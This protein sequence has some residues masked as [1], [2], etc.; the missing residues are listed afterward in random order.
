[1]AV[2]HVKISTIADSTDLTLVRP[3][4]WNSSHT[5]EAGSI[6]NI[7]ISTAAAVDEAKITFSTA[8]GH[9]HNAVNSKAVDHV[10]LLNKGSNS[11]A[12]IDTHISAATPH[13]GHENSANKNIANG[14]QGLNANARTSSTNI[15]IKAI[16]ATPTLD[17][18]LDDTFSAGWI[19]GG[20][21]FAS[22]TTV[23]VDA[24]E[25]FI[26][27][28]SASSAPIY[29]INW[30]SASTAIPAGQTRYAIVA[31]N[32]GAP[33]V[34]FATS[35]PT[36]RQS[37]LY[38]A[39]IHNINSTLHIHNDP[40]V[41]ADLRSRQRDWIA[42]LIGTRVESGG[43]VSDPASPSRKIAITACTFW[44]RH[45]R[46][47]TTPAFNSNV[48]DTF[49]TVYR[50]GVGEWTR[51]I[52][53]TNWPNT[54]YDNGSGT[55][56]AMTIL[57]YANVWVIRVFEGLCYVQ[58]GQAEY[59]TQAAAEAEDPPA[60]KPEEVDEHGFYIAQITFQKSAT[61]PASIGQIQPILG[62]TGTASVSA[63]NELSGLQGGQ[64][65]Q[66]YHLTL[67]QSSQL[68]TNGNIHD[69]VGGDGAQINHTGLSNIG[70][71]THAVIDTHIASTAN[72]HNTNKTDVGLSNITN[73]AQLKR[74]D[75]DINSFTEKITPVAGDV[76]I[77]ESSADAFAKRKVQIGNLPSGGGGTPS[78]AVT[79]ELTFGISSAAGTSTTFSRGDHTH[80]TPPNPI[81][82]GSS[83]VQ[84]DIGDSSAAGISTSLAREDH[85]H[86][87]PAPAAGYPLDVSSAEA[88][89]T[90]SIPAR[91]DHIHK[92]GIVTLKGDLLS[93]DTNP[94]RFGVGTNGQL[95]EAD[96]VQALGVKWASQ[97]F[98]KGGNVLSPS[99]GNYSV[100]RAPY[101]CTV[102]NVRGYRQAGTGATINARRNGASNHLASDL[103]VASTGAW[104]DGGV[105]QNTAYIAGDRLEIMITTLSGTPTEVAV[106]VDFT[107]P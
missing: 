61:S 1:M 17:A 103:S 48:T 94:A 47:L 58:Y 66:Y 57:Y 21:A 105:V 13:S 45:L 106:Q 77:V 85:Q 63:H 73:D 42:G 37:N 39:E 15:S 43:V 100:W 22:G 30:S 36:D 32:A 46:Q 9:V 60:T 54:D 14:Y 71:N 26:R 55:L 90:T 2:K 8:S 82:Y 101:A 41:F 65:S 64:A 75:G 49:T 68:V 11:H 19:Q 91:A 16:N 62:V 96:S 35:F 83:I 33:I 92:M 98:T 59:A 76:I 74:A 40:I 28:S 12:N 102:T 27:S 25:G 56:A 88:D 107:R 24:G 84:I 70:T 23:V 93:F 104:T 89:G 31:Y 67:A 38:L 44:D 81:T 7:D 51:T 29:Y 99:T 80:G 4:D 86:G 50:N 79:G 95:V 20:S 52:G 53:Q 6:I 69:H 78:G 97:L 72:P 34:Q 87:F 18:I 5:I 10:D 3:T